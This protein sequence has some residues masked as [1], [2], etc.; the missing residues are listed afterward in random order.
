[1]LTSFRGLAQ[2]IKL[3][4]K[5]KACL[6][7]DSWQSVYIDYLLSPVTIAAIGLLFV[8]G[9]VFFVRRGFVHIERTMDVVLA[10]M[11]GVLFYAIVMVFALLLM[12]LWMILIDAF[13]CIWCLLD[14]GF[15]PHVRR[16]AKI[17]F[18]NYRPKQTKTILM[19]TGFSAL[20]CQLRFQAA[21]YLDV[22][23]QAINKRLKVAEP[24]YDSIS[25]GDGV[26]I[27]SVSG[28]FSK[29]V[30]LQKVGMDTLASS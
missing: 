12:H 18:K 29:R 22:D 13:N 2:E 19:P 8:A 21:Y 17:Q 23:I 16:S 26:D 5:I 7:N 4:K 14:F 15:R 3:V 24:F 27:T 11:A 9:L 6:Q 25:T 20:P 30:Y 28:R 1:M 10:I